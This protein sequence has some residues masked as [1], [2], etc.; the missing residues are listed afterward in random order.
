MPLVVKSRPPCKGGASG[1]TMV[2]E[3]NMKRMTVG[4]LIDELSGYDR[5]QRVSVYFRG[6]DLTPY[7]LVEHADETEIAIYATQ[8]I[9]DPGSHYSDLALSMVNKLDKPEHHFRPRE[10][11][12]AMAQ[13]INN[14]IG[15]PMVEAVTVEG[16]ARVCLRPPSLIAELP[17]EAPSAFSLLEERIMSNKALRHQISSCEEV[18]SEL[19]VAKRLADDINGD[20][21]MDVVEAKEVDGVTTVSLMPE[22]EAMLE[23]LPKD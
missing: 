18:L 19:D 7:K 15:L 5:S 20:A 4:E 23:D 6:L 17:S 22:I 3:K 14:E 16:H 9:G 10:W 21:G 11:A 13:R 2:L 1:P 8:F 12:E